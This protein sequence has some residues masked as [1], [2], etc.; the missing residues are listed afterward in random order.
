MTAL[1][2]VSHFAGYQDYIFGAVRLGVENFYRVVPCVVLHQR[3][4]YEDRI[5]LYFGKAKSSHTFPKN[6]HDR[7]ADL[8]YAQALSD[9]IFIRKRKSCQFI[10]DQA[11][12]AARLLVN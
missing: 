7:E 3:E 10:G 11:H 9:R 12:F 8:P 5:S 2:Q 6:A 1:Q 4:R